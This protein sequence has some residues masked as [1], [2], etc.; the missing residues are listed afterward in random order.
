L[1]EQ[2]AKKQVNIEETIGDTGR[3]FYFSFPG[4]RMLWWT[5]ANIWWSNTVVTCEHASSALLSTR[6]QFMGRDTESKELGRYGPGNSRHMEPDE[7]GAEAAP[8]GAALLGTLGPD[9]SVPTTPRGASPTPGTSVANTTDTVACRWMTNNSNVRLLSFYPMLPSKLGIQNARS[10][11]DMPWNSA[12]HT[13]R[14]DVGRKDQGWAY[15]TEAPHPHHTR[16]MTP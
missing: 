1:W 13:Y 11:N 9:I 15:W 3:I 8:L 7:P 14:V 5:E 4:Q 10:G 16:R 6:L 12:P 2:G